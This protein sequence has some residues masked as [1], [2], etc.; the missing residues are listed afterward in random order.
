MARQI[1]SQSGM[2]IEAIGLTPPMGMPGSD[3][4]QKHEPDHVTE[5]EQEARDDPESEVGC[6]GVDVKEHQADRLVAIDV[7]ADPWSQQSENEPK[8]PAMDAH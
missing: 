8:P 3:P 6:A 7:G 1:D 2:P 4:T 5:G